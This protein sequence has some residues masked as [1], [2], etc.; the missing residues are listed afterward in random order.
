MME[1]TRDVILDLMPLY[2][3]GEASADTQSLV[4]EYLERDP[5]LAQLARQWRARLPGPPPA[6]VHPE[7]QALAYLE[8]KR[9]IQIKTIGLAAAITAGFLA[10]ATLVVFMFFFDLG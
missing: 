8:A 9:Q 10:L 5:D 7:A 1:A 4:N 6:P 2:L 3:A